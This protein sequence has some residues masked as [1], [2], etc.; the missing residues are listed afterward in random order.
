MFLYFDPET[1][2]VK[3]YSL[4]FTELEEVNDAGFLISGVRGKE[5]IKKCDSV[6]ASKAKAKC[7]WKEPSYLNEELG[8]PLED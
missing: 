3:L 7:I 1:E 2:G 6:S 5:Y 8:L 4:P